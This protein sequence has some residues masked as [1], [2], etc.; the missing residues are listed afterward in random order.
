MARF[1][2]RLA[3]V[4]V[5]GATTLWG[6]LALHYAGPEDG[7][8]NLLAAGFAV[9]GA[10]CLLASLLR[11]RHARLFGAALGGYTVALLVL[12]AWW[13]GIEPSND[14]DWR[15]EESRLPYATIDGDLV[16]VYNIRNFDYRTE[17]DFTPGYVER[18]FD[19]RRLEA[20]DLSAVYWMGPA[21]AHIYLSFVFTDQPPLAISIEARKERGEQYSSLAGFFRQYELFY[22]VAD[23]RDVTRVRTNY[24]KDPPEQVYLYRLRGKPENR[25]RIFLEYFRKINALRTEPEFYNTLTT[26]CTTV[27][28]QH[29]LV[30]PEHLPFSWKILASGYLPEY[31]YEAGVLGNSLPFEQLRRRSHINAAAHAADKASDFSRRIRAG[32]PS[33]DGARR[34]ALR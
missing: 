22:V 7:P 23:E 20:I 1:V 28:W 6:S 10:G 27:I 33:I 18:R 8:R 34:A 19:L 5:I 29:S 17:S 25:R 12:L 32:L 4:L 2:A 14:R 31:L 15:A 3:F 13:H 26:N 9:L 30:N 16:T 24:R 21:I 11:R